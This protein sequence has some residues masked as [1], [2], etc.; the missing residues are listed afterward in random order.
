VATVFPFRALRPQPALAREVASV[1]Y[2]VVSSDEARA[3]AQGNP[4]SFLQVTKPEIAL[5]PKTDPHDARVYATGAEALR[6]L[7]SDRVLVRDERPGFYVYA[8]TWQGRTQTGVAHLA[9]IDEYTRNIVRRHE[10]TRPDKEDDRVH[11]LEAVNAQTGIVFLLHK[12][13]APLRALVQ[14]TISVA[15]EIDFTAADEVRHQVWPVPAAHNAALARAFADVG[16]LYIADGHHRS[17]A[18]AR[19]SPERRGDPPGFLAVSF[20]MSSSARWA[21]PSRSWPSARPRRSAATSSAC[22]SEAAGSP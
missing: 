2:D 5:P 1:P 18:A 15:P 19:I 16:P 12:D 9:S 21:R 14:Q 7:Q 17:A 3:L 11:H 20:P 8:L 4:I 22:S 10:H 6:R 13:H